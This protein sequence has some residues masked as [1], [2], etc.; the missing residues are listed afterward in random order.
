MDKMKYG[1]NFW[2]V[3]E[4]AVYLGVSRSLVY[5]FVDKG[6]IPCIRLG[7]R[8]LIPSRYVATLKV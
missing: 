8:I 3:T 1:K 6:K 4:V 2:S 7:S 5:A